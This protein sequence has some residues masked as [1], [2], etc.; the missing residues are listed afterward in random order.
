MSSPGD[1]LMDPLALALVASLRHTRVSVA[2]GDP[3]P[4]HRRGSLL[5][6]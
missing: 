1:R 4:D 3:C 5:A 6:S 2:A